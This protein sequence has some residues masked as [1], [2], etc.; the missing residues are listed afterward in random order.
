M[1]GVP[2]AARQSTAEPLQYM[3]TDTEGSYRLKTALL[4]EVCMSEHVGK[5]THKIDRV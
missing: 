2:K 5:L 4:I 3:F 1:M